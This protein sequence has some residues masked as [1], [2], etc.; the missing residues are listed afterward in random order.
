M[1]PNARDE[2]PPEAVASN[3]LLGFARKHTGD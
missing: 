3:A 1:T 2:A